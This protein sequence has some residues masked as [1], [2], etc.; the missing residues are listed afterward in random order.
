M[1][2]VTVLPP[3]HHSAGHGCNSLDKSWNQSKP[4]DCS[5]VTTPLHHWF[6]YSLRPLQP[7]SMREMAK[8]T[9]ETSQCHDTQ[10]HCRAEKTIL[11]FFVGIQVSKMFT[12]CSLSKPSALYSTMTMVP[13]CMQQYVNIFWLNGHLL[14]VRFGPNGLSKRAWWRPLTEVYKH[15]NFHVQS[16][17]Q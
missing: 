4:V 12:R 9:V 10:R 16:N 8:A 1:I 7:A 11:C 6:H 13:F 5:G 3:A 17:L 2:C 14:A 15:V